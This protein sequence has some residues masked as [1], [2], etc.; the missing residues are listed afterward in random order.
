M[1][2]RGPGT[3]GQHSSHPEAFPAEP[4]MADR[5]HS[6]MNAVEPSTS[7][8][9]RPALAADACPLEL[10][11]RNNSV[12]ARRDSCDH[13]IRVGIADFCIHVDA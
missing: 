4:R 11:E 8:T 1:A 2:E 6:A 3:D 12:L 7:Q 10:R 13:R 9:R 5:E